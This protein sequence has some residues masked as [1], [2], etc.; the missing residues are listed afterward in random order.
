MP[1]RTPYLLCW[2]AERHTY[3]LETNRDT[4][5]SSPS[6]VDPDSPAWFAWLDTVVAFSFHRASGEGWTVRQEPGQRGGAYWYAYRRVAGRR[7]KRYL[8]RTS[9]LTL[10]RLVA[11]TTDEPAGASSGAPAEHVPNALRRTAVREHANRREHR[12][13]KSKQANRLRLPPVNRTRQRSCC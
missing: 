1:K 2:S 12:R 11:S 5:T 9:D 7:I 8:G 10:A 6:P 13:G 3:S 4:F